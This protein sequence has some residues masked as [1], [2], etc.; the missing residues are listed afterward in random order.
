MLFVI[1]SWHVS[2]IEASIKEKIDPRFRGND[3]ILIFF[4][5]IQQT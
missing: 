4:V 5:V 1:I 3:R 2:E